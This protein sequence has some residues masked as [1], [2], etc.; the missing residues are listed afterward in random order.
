MRRAGSVAGSG[1]AIGML[2]DGAVDWPGKAHNNH[3][4]TSTVGIISQMATRR[5]VMVFQLTTFRNSGDRRLLC[6]ELVAA[7]R[8]GIAHQGSADRLNFQLSNR[9]IRDRGPP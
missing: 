8:M 9:E 3:A 7:G 4:S 2:R 6:H 1:G 5:A